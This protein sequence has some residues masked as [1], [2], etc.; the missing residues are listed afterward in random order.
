MDLLKNGAQFDLVQDILGSEISLELIQKQYMMNLDD[1]EE[2]IDESKLLPISVDM[3]ARSKSIR[4]NDKFFEQLL[5]QAMSDPNDHFLDPI[6]Y[7]VMVDPV[8]LS[9]G[10]VFDR[11]TI[12]DEKGQLKYK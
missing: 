12:Q 4:K 3:L 6:M 10:H 2:Q 1:E 8:V 9:S 11:Q 5:E 7:N